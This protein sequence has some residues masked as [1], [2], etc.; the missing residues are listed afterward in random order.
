MD[1]MLVTRQDLQ[2]AARH[3]GNEAS[4]DSVAAA[5]IERNGQISVIKTRSTDK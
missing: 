5:F 3:E 4:L 1:A 2:E